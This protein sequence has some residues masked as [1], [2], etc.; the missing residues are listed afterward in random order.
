MDTWTVA[1]WALLI[2]V[3]T[4]G[5]VSIIAAWKA[6]TAANQATTASTNAVQAVK[7]VDA[8]HQAVNSKMD[9]LLTANATVARAE[10]REAGVRAGQAGELPPLSG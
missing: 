6:N 10:G 2:G 3:I 9:K 1:D 8:T 4:T 7:I 5:I